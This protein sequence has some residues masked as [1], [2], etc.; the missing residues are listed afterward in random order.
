MCCEPAHGWG[1]MGGSS[2]A[3]HS[4]KRGVTVDI[5]EVSGL[6]PSTPHR[7]DAMRLVARTRSG[8]ARGRGALVLAMLGRTPSD[9]RLPPGRRN[10]ATPPCRDVSPWGQ[11]LPDPAWRP[12]EGGCFVRFAVDS[13]YTCVHPGCW[14]FVCRLPAVSPQ[15]VSSV[16]GRS[17]LL[18][19]R[20]RLGRCGVRANVDPPTGKTGRQS[21]ILAFSTDG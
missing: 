9:A 13:R 20:H 21:G 3:P 7:E 15:T 4:L 18:G 17:R 10:V 5:A 6:T 11:E 14:R 8:S 2:S 1:L 16:P 19:V 12:P